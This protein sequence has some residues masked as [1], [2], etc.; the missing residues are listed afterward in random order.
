MVPSPLNPSVNLDQLLTHQEWALRVAR[1]LVHEEG[2][3]EDLVQRT[4]IAAMRRPPV[5]PLGIKA[6]IHKV[7]LNLARERHRRQL[8]RARHEQA[9]TREHPEAPDPADFLG[10]AELGTILAEQLL[11][12]SEPYRSV[13][14]ARYYDGHSSAE[15]AR[16]LGI[17]SGTVR[18]RLKVG[19]DQLRAGLDR[20]AHG[21]RARWVSAFVALLPGGSGAGAHAVPLEG[22]EPRATGLALPPAAGWIGLASLVGIGVFLLL[23]GEDR[24]RATDLTALPGLLELAPDMDSAQGHRADRLVVPVSATP[25]VETAPAHPAGLSVSVTDALGQP[26]ADALIAVARAEGFEKRATTDGE[27]RARLMVRLED[28][29]SLGL[30][31]TQDRVSIRAFASGHVASPL[32]HVAPPFTFDH[33]VRLVVGGPDAGVRGRLIDEQGR[34]VPGAVVAWFEPEEQLEQTPEGDFPSPSYVSTRSDEEGSFE[35]DNLPIET[36]LLGVIAAGYMLYSE[37]IDL[38][39]PTDP[40]EILLARGATLTGRVRGPDGTPLAGVRVGCE[41]LVKAA[42]WATG[43]PGYEARWRGFGETARS[44]ENGLF[45]LEG[46]QTMKARTVWAW[47]EARGL[48]ARHS[49]AADSG[50]DDWQ[51]ELAPGPA[52]RL[53]LVDESQRPLAGWFGLLRRPLEADVLWTRRIAADAE[54]RIELLDCP[55]GEAVLDVFAPNDAGGSYAW[56]SLHP[57]IEEQVVQIDVERRSVLRGRLV[58]DLGAPERNGRLMARSERTLLCTQL[59]RDDQGRFEQ[60]LAPGLYLLTLQLPQTATALGRFR[61]RPGEEQDVGVLTTPPLGLLRLDGTALFD[62]GAVQPRYSLLRLSDGSDPASLKVGTGEL[63]PEVL[64]PVFPGRYRIL[65]VDSA[66]ELRQ[67]EIE[68]GSDGE[69]RVELAPGRSSPRMSSR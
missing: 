11:E 68:V 60:E 56:R 58:D 27:G 29:G 3:A 18:W 25:S 55:A 46:I 50:D 4:W 43:L 54:G 42:E 49:L 38:R 1:Q 30:P 17:P 6:W 16:R 57:T 10:R 63:N 47:D 19:L 7:I 39:E 22:H 15:I 26:V 67:T 34:G 40:F 59:A 52:F 61:V 64:L 24:A 13:V 12:L 20:R 48:V 37:F 2:E 62:R 9:A 44:D 33:E 69:A 5:D 66:G 28:P 36:G 65:S 45:R 8:A 14:I 35:L 32:V 53:R 23:H 51:V 31:V 41:P 21:D